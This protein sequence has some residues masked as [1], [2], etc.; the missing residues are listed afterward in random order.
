VE[1]GN[2]AKK[3]AL[4]GAGAGLVLFLVIGLLYGSFIGGIA[5]LNI[6]GGLFGFPVNSAV[7]PR[8]IVSISMILGIFISGIFF[9]G[10]STIIGWLIG[11]AID[12]L[13][14]EKGKA[15]SKATSEGN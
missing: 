4:V 13:K 7:L 9:V 2:A 11:R 14:A 5:G 10:G 8:L 12:S 15:T 1:T 6:A 3:T